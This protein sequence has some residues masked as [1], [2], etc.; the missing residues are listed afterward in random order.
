MGT[1]HRSHA[2]RA[3]KLDQL[4]LD[5]SQLRTIGEAS[6]ISGKSWTTLRHWADSGRVRSLR[7]GGRR[8]LVLDDLKRLLDRER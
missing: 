8:L 4:A 5:L 7:V 6:R 3:L 1:D 2:K